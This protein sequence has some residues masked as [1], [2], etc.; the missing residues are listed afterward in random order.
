MTRDEVIDATRD[1]IRAELAKDAG[2]LRP[3]EPLL[4]SGVITSFDLVSLT[5]FLEE[6]FQVRVPDAKVSR[7]HLD[8]LDQIAALVLDL[9]GARSSGEGRVRERSLVERAI[10]TFRQ[11]APLVLL[12]I[13]LAVVAA[14]R[15]VD[16]LLSREDVR[17]RLEGQP[18]SLMQG[19]WTSRKRMFYCYPDYARAIERHELGRTPKAPD[20]IRI[21]FQG[22]S[23][24]FGSYLEPEEACPA[25]FERCVRSSVPQARVY[26]LSYFGQSFVKDAEILEAGLPY[27][28]DLVIVSLCSVHLNR[29]QIDWW[30][31]PPTTL[32]HNRPLFDRF[33]EA[34]PSRAR[35]AELD[36][37]LADSERRH[38]MNWLHRFER[39]SAIVRDQKLIQPL[40]ASI[41]FPPGLQVVQTA[42]ARALDPKACRYLR[43]KTTR[44]FPCLDYPLDERAAALL[45]AIIDRARAAG[46]EVALLQEPEPTVPGDPPRRIPW[47]EAGWKAYRDTVA[48]IA[49]EKNVVAVDGLDLLPASEFL[50][51]ERHWTVEGN[52]AVGRLV[53]EKLGPLVAKLRERRR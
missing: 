29:D 52:E 47:D 35:F 41:L 8:T 2:P 50:D 18:A 30:V 3:D 11:S 53:A 51:S 20:E 23:G 27:A 28:P 4:S 1:F 49:R 15:L 17:A 26:N 24:T 39:R 19:E 36:A 48:R 16:R 9:G 22:D 34:A 12:A 7:D 21:V 44:D 43:G 33:F 38:G 37:I 6:R 5:V 13:A 10:P 31:K 40:V 25:V 32:V 45:E 42:R 14:D 46:S